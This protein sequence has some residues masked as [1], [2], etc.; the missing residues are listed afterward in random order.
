MRRPLLAAGP[1]VALLLAASVPLLQ[2]TFGTP[3]DRV[4]PTSAASR[5]VGDALRTGFAGNETTAV[6][7][8]DDGSRG[9]GTTGGICSGAVEPAVGGARGHQRGD[10]RIRPSGGGESGRPV[11]GHRL[12][13]ATCR[14]SPPWTPSP[15]RRRTSSPTSG[16]SR[17]RPGS[18][19]LVGGATA[20]RWP[21]AWTP[22]P[23]GYRWRRA[24]IALTTFV[25]LFL[26]TGSI[27]QPVRALM[28]QHADPGSDAR[29]HGA[30]VP[31][32]ASDRPCSGSRRSL[33]TCRCWCCS[34]AS[35]SGCRWTTRCS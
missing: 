11:A 9:G 34:S 1:V 21:T 31:G 2:V 13:A 12:G 16:I 5:Q 25:V 33:S 22:S 17:H 30:R 24:W 32:G 18:S 10:V 26:F 14:W 3:D 28:Q 6:D 4:L 23:T 19:A 8:V 15:R 7:V 29:D 20:R 35:P 27:V